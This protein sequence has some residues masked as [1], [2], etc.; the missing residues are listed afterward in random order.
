M[1]KWQNVCL[2]LLTAELFNLL[3]GET[4]QNILHYRSIKICV[5]FEFCYI[6]AAGD[7][8]HYLIGYVS[9][10][11]HTAHIMSIIFHYCDGIACSGRNQHP[12]SCSRLRL[13]LV[14]DQES[15]RLAL[16]S[17]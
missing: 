2:D 15:Y 14:N 5:Y 13:I 11:L 17:I 3:S 7:M 12:L 16:A 4:S 6:P 9:L 1:K 10:V 8:Q